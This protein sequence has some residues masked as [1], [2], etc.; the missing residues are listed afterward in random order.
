VRFQIVRAA[1]RQAAVFWVTD[2]SEVH[3]ASIIREMSDIVGEHV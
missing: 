3:A 2:V 1:S